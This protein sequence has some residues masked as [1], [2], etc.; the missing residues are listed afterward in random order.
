ML[1]RR[2]LQRQEHRTGSKVRE[3]NGRPCCCE[4]DFLLMLRSH[5][6]IF[7]AHNLH[8]ESGPNKSLHGDTVGSETRDPP[9]AQPSICATLTDLHRTAGQELLTRSLSQTHALQLLA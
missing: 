2:A 8:P 3:C 1:A 5:D 9:Y 4:Y 7:A 6:L